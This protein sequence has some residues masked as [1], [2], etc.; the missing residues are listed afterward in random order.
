MKSLRQAVSL[1]CLF[2][3]VSVANVK[4]DDDFLSAPP[5]MQLYMAYAEFKMAHYDVAQ[6]MW[7]SIQG[8][9]AG[10][11]AFNLGI[12]YEQGKGVDAN[13]ETAINY[14]RQAA[15]NGS[16]AG[17]YQVGLMHFAHEQYVDAEEAAHWLSV[18]ALDGDK[19]AADLLLRLDSQTGSQNHSEDPL[20]TVKKLLAQGQSQQALDKLKRLAEQTP[21]NFAAVTELAWLYETG[22]AVERDI[23]KAGELFMIAAQG[24]NAKAQYALAVMFETGVGQPQN[25]DQAALW[26]QRAAEQAY[27]PAL[28]KLN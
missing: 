11:A 21:P 3:A 22:L 14:Y 15:E 4:L 26:L 12:L 1:L 9:G 10:E 24:G 19:D 7:R 5:K 18:A 8:K 6:A 2:S 28:N 16:R 27:Q 23:N 25:E 17:A 13:I 20:F